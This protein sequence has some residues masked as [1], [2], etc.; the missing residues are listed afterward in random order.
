[1][2]LHWWHVAISYLLTAAVFGALFARCRTA[3]RGEADAGGST[4]RGR[5]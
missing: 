3:P 4:R 5:P 1:M 2:T